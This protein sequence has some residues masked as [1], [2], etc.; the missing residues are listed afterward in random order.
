MKTRL[1]IIVCLLAIVLPCATFAKT[2]TKVTISIDEPTVGGLPPQNASVPETASTEITAVSWSG[3]FDGEKFIQGNNYSVTIKIKVKDSSANT[4]SSSSPVNATVNGKKARVS[5]NGAKSITVKYTWKTLGGENPNTPQYKIKSQLAELAKAYTATNATDDKEVLEYLR[6]KLPQAEIWCAG[7]AYKYTRKMPSETK[8]GNFSM[9][10]GITMDGIT[11][12]RYGFLAVIPAL[13]KSEDAT[14]LDADRVLMEAALRDFDT[15]AKTT[16]EEILAAL[17]AAATHG[18]QAAWGDK[19]AYDAPSS[20]SRGSIEGDIIISLGDKRAIISAHKVLPID[21]TPDDAAVDEDFSAILRA[22]KA[23]K[24]TKNTTEQELM[25]I[26]NAAIKNDSKLTCTSFSVSLPDYDREGK[27]VLNMELELNGKTRIPRFAAS[28]PMEERIIENFP[29]GW[30]VNYHEWEVLRLTNIER[31]KKGVGPLIMAPELITTADLRAKEIIQ[32]YSHTR[33]NG[34]PFYV[35]IDHVFILNK[36]TG[37]NI[38]KMAKTPEQVVTAWMN[39]P[40]HRANMLKGAFTYFGCGVAV[41]RDVKHWVQL[42]ATGGGMVTAKTSNGIYHFETIEQM[43]QA[44]VICT[45]NEGYTGYIPLEADCMIRNGNSFTYKLE[46][47]SIT[48]TV[49][50]INE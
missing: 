47:T 42:F 45:T 33:P 22:L 4:F 13:N 30:S 39:S 34:S 48:V 12:E 43:E 20:N 26:A 36:I 15:T 50:N 44:I 5:Y 31:H 23:H 40:G 21:G 9:T 38:A 8:D 49:A 16:P 32:E 3:E 17:N 18:T 7:G 27:V 6:K 19:F 1:M 37:E 2:I 14:N 25:A 28:L 10:I 24:V 35:A 46:G 41:N 11:I 29:D